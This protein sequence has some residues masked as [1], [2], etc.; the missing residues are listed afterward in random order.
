MRKKLGLTIVEQ[1]IALVPGFEYVVRKL[2]Q[3]VHKGDRAIAH[4]R[5]TS[6]ALPCLWFILTGR[7]GVVIPVYTIISTKA[8]NISMDV[9]SILS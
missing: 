6:T 9:R 7:N 4:I 3:Q 5:F 8:C 1:A 2:E